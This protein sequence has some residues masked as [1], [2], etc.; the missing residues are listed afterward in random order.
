MSA[1]GAYVM[2]GRR[3]VLAEEGWIQVAVR[4]DPAA[5]PRDA[6]LAPAA[7]RDAA[8]FPTSATRGTQASQ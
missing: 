3:V 8:A 4:R 7:K 1:T 2:D 6:E 5:A